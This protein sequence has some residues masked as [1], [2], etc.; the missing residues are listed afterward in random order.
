MKGKSRNRSPASLFEGIEDFEIRNQGGLRK[1][2]E[3][4][5][6]NNTTRGKLHWSRQGSVNMQFVFVIHPEYSLKYRL[7]ALRHLPFPSM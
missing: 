7:T 3:V 5:P 6:P 1:N 2:A 4:S